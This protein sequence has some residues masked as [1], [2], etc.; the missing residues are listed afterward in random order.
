M[1]FTAQAN[2]QHYPNDRRNVRRPTLPERKGR[3]FA[4]EHTGLAT[5]DVAYLLWFVILIKMDN[6]SVVLYDLPVSS[7]ID[8]ILGMDFLIPNRAIVATH[9][10]EIYMPI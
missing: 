7:Q 10:A 9:E 1:W 8:G 4:I 3:S 2:E 5:S 6:F